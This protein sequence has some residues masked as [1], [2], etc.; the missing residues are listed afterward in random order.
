M[1]E[2]HKKL[3]LKV[4]EF[5]VM[6]IDKYKYTPSYDEIGNAMKMSPAYISRLVTELVELGALTRPRDRALLKG[7]ADIEKWLK[8]I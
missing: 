1:S 3:L 4:Y 7:E 8:D 2:K 6:F 5:V